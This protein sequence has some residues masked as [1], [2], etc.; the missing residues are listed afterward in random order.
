MPTDR[1]F[2][3]M[4]LGWYMDIPFAGLHFEAQRLRWERSELKGELNITGMIPG[5]TKAEDGR[6]HRASFNFSS[7]VS[8]KSM[9]ELVGKRTMLIDD[10]DLFQEIEGFCTYVLDQETSGAEVVTLAHIDPMRGP[11]NY[12]VDGIL[13]LTQTTIFFGDGGVGKSYLAA[14]LGLSI[15]T[16]LEVVPGFRPVHRGPVLYL[17]WETD[18]VEIRSRL[19]QIRLG[20][21][22]EVIP[23]TYRYMAMAGA[24]VKQTERII[25]QVQEDRSQLVVVDSVGMASGVGHEASDAN[26]TT[27]RLFSALREIGTTVLALDH[28]SK[29]GAENER[30]AFKP[31]GSAYKVNL[32]RSVFE[33]R[34]GREEI[35]VVGIYHRKA[36]NAALREPVGLRYEHGALPDGQ[37]AMRFVPAPITDSALASGLPVREQ[38][39]RALRH[40]PMTSVDLAEELGKEHNNV[41]AV[42]SQLFQKGYVVKS[43]ER[44]A[45]AAREEA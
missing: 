22:M 25:K 33:L 18:A 23:E 26:E 24:L 17:D 28:V 35:D 41:R 20:L 43:G 42:L 11:A 31:Y 4:G 27:I 15:A 29:S 3:R 6:I 38:V 45:L 30:G 19:E 14:G 12:L 1:F 10:I 16:G 2:G 21:G 39:Y 37:Q 32:A 34:R 9:A 8:R 44:W 13:P 7:T 36:N 40:G 5:T